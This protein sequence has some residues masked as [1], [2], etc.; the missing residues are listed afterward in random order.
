M[1][2]RVARAESKRTMA[3][4]NVSMVESYSRLNMG[5]AAIGVNATKKAMAEYTFPI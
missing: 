2:Q 1:V 3:A 5:L 4:G